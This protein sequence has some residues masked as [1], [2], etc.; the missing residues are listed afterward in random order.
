VRHA[1]GHRD[2]VVPEPQLD[3]VVRIR[4]TGASPVRNIAEA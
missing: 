4:H 3:G 1:G 2:A